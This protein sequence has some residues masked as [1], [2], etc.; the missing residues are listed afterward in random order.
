MDSE[1]T[2]SVM[3]IF[4]IL[5]KHIKAIWITTLVVFLAS[6]FVTFF[7]MTPKYEATTEILVNRKLSASMQAAQY[8][9]V[10]ADVQM[11]STYKDIITSPTVLKTVNN[12][13]SGYPGYPGSMRALKNAISISNQQ[14][15]Q[16][17]SI[18]VKATDAKTAATIANETAKVFKKQVVKMMSVHNVSIVSKATPNYS[19]VSPRKTIN[20]AIGLIVGLILGI[21]LALLREVTD[22]TVTSESYLTDELGL[23][24]LGIVSEIDDKEVKKRITRERHSSDVLITGADGKVEARSR[25]RV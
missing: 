5:R 6:I 11:I 8:Q 1:Q 14:N 15:S 22:R 10:Q 23:T 19:A 25:R 12:T 7:V 9:Q 2:I 24:S 16:V 21:G 13:T 3:Q 20:L 17:F 18:T 4:G